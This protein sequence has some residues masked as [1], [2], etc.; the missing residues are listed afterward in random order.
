L[1]ELSS[2]NDATSS[3]WQVTRQGWIF[4]VLLVD[5]SHRVE[6]FAEVLQEFAELVGEVDLHAFEILKLIQEE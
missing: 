5:L 3:G 4:L 6:F 2:P 1:V